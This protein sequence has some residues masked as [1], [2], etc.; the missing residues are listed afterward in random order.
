MEAVEISVL[1]DTFS[2]PKKWGRGGCPES[3]HFQGAVRLVE[4]GVRGGH[5]DEHEGL[6]GAAQ[7]VGHQHRQLV[8]AVRDVH[9]Q[10]PSR[11]PRRL[12]LF[13]GPLFQS[14]H[15]A[16]SAAC[17]ITAGSTVSCFECPEK[18]CLEVCPVAIIDMFVGCHADNFRRVPASIEGMR[19]G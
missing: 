6:G 4:I 12:R 10:A 13:I 9:L 5:V 11:P 17:A 19:L 3:A 15:E 7:G 2:D 8:V 16:R 14:R 18:V 1:F